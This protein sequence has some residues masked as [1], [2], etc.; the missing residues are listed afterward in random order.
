[1]EFHMDRVQPIAGVQTLR[2]YPP[3]EILWIEKQ[4]CQK[5][6]EQ[7][8]TFLLVTWVH[9]PTIG[10]RPYLTT[11]IITLSEFFNFV[12]QVSRL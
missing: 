10:E 6:L 7:N 1:M 4:F 2:H 5:I 11:K 3:P 8:S 9:V 12:H